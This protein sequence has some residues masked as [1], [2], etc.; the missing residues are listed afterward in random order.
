MIT[1]NSFQVSWVNGPP[2]FTDGRVVTH[3]RVS[4][5]PADESASQTYDVPATAW[6][7]HTFNG[8]GTGIVHNV[9]ID[10]LVSTNGAAAEVV[11]VNTQIDVTT[12]RC[13]FRFYL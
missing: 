12:C 7:S 3:Y 5:T 11:D 13:N 9:R 4:V 8:L 10:A 2:T 1:T 6:T